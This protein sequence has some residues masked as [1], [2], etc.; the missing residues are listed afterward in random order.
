MA[1]SLIARVRWREES[2]AGRQDEQASG[3][4]GDV[5]AG[6]ARVSL[7]QRGRTADG[8]AAVLVVDGRLTQNTVRLKT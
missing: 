6:G 7:L 5:D 4:A 3:Q 2:E 8:S 1:A